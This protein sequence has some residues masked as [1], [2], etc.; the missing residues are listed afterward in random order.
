MIKKP[1]T[2]W[3]PNVIA[4]LIFITGAAICL[5]KDDSLSALVWAVLYVG[6]AIHINTEQSRADDETAYIKRR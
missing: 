2:S 4:G 5:F 3:S 6:Q 1:Y